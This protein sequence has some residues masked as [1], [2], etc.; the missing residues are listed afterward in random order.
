VVRTLEKKGLVRRADHPG[1]ARAFALEPTAAGHA[2]LAKAM[3]AVEGADDRF[4]AR[5]RS[6]A[7]LADALRRLA[8][9]E[10]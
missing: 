9:E 6:K 10:D 4:F 3:P 5:V 1:D 7:G 2:V 8:A